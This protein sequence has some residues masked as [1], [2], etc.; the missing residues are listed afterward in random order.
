MKNVISVQPILSA[1]LD[2]ERNPNDLA[3]GLENDDIDVVSAVLSF[4]VK[5]TARLLTATSR[6]FIDM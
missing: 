5:H 6:N 2:V 3:I 4:S 1:V